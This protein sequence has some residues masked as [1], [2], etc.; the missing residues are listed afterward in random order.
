MQHFWAVPLGA[1][2]ADVVESLNAILKRACNDH[3]AHDREGGGVLG[4]QSLES[5]VEVVWE[6]WELWCSQ[7]DIALGTLATPHVAPCT[8]TTPMSTQGHTALSFAQS[9]PALCSL[10]DGPGHDGEDDG[11][12]NGQSGMPCLCVSLLVFGVSLVSFFV[13]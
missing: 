3:T 2:F 1:V 8:M 11:E 12:E 4:A 7:L 9:T 5:S 13:T 10:V 6:V